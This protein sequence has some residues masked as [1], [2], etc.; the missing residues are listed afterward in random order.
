MKSYLTLV[1]KYLSAHKK[2]T[3]LV[4]TSVAISVALITGIFSMLDVFQKFEKM[5][6]IHDYGNYHI[7]IKDAT[8][9]ERV[10]I[11]SRI[12]VKT[13]GEWIFLKNGSLN[14]KTCRMD[15]IE[16]SIAPNMR[17]NLLEGKYPVAENQMMLE[18]W[19]AESLKLKVGDTV[20]LVFSD[21]TVKPFLLSGICSDYSTTKAGDQPTALLSVSGANAA[22]AEKISRLYIEFKNGVNVNKAQKDIQSSLQLMDD[23]IGRNEYLLA[24]IG[25]STENK[26]TSLYIAG[27]ILFCIVLMAGV[28]MIYNTFNI[29]VMERIQQ[30]GLLRCIGASQIQIKK[31]VRREGLHITLRAIP[32]GLLGGILITFFCTAL[33]KFYNKNLFGEISLFQFSIMGIVAGIAVGFL[34]VLI[35]SFVPAKKAAKV[36][37]VNAVTGSSDLKISKKKKQGLLTRMFHV[38][39][40][41]GINNAIVKKKTLLLMSCSIAISIVMFLGFQVFID[42]LNTSMKTSKPY[43]PDITLTSEN[44]L[45][46]DLYSNLRNMDG[47]KAVYGRMFGYVKATFDASKL[48]DSYK[49]SMGGIPTKDNGLFDAPEPSWLISYDRNQLDWANADLLEGELSEEKLNA[50]NGIIAVA[51]NLRNNISTETTSFQLGDKVFI[52]TPNGTK[53]MTVMGILR[54]VPFNDSV[55]SMTM[56]I[57]TEKLFTQLTGEESYQA[58]DIQLKKSGQEDTFNQIKSL[59]NSSTTVYDARQKNA[60]TNQTFFTMAVFIYGFVLVIALISI[61]NIIN[62]MNTS[63]ASKTRYLGVMRAIGMSGTQ[64]DR[65]VTVEAATYSLSGC[66]IGSVAGIALQKALITFTLSSYHIV[67]KFPGAQIGLIFLLI[68][69]IT[70]ISVI[71]PLKRIKKQG[72]SEVI[73]S[74]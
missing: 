12:D 52:E 41:M 22:N 6:M 33:L 19:A 4:V 34:T 60:E 58:I 23:R 57:T 13:S 73:G 51:K 62:T 72:V 2:K 74:L 17:V 7:S 43:T 64:L 15:A 66:V 67:W 8:E 29:S 42:F 47:T 32:I 45:S 54:S 50:Q 30:F 68:L 35:A 20:K 69:V 10:V 18:E 3:R 55:L 40:A 28:M 49:E 61:L 44:S 5:Q 11:S 63:V 46:S 36:S 37:P 70:V 59:L 26:A 39:T 53:E 21:N 9:K 14:G 24:A 38:E 48:T 16:E 65:M 71:S 56:F 31:L 1:T 25:Q 27:G